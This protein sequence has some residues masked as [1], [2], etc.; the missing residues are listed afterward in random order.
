MPDSEQGLNE[1]LTNPPSTE[2]KPNLAP[3]HEA[4]AAITT[5][6]DTTTPSITTANPSFSIFSHFEKKWISSIASFGAMF[7]TLSSYIYFPALV[8]DGHRLWRVCHAHQPDRHFIP[9]CC[10]SRAR[11]HG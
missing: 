4:K 10:W 2:A 1:I 8:P 7:S 5:T 9:H 6:N 11:I 3:K